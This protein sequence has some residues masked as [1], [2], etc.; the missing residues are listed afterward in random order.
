MEEWIKCYSKSRKR[1][2]YF[3]QTTGRSV[4]SV[5]ELT[6][7]NKAASAKTTESP[8]GLNKKTSKVKFKA[9]D[10]LNSKNIIKSSSCSSS[11]ATSSKL[12]S[13]AII[14]SNKSIIIEKTKNK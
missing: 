9:K 10:K 1:D 6:I 11:P 5:E 13:K 2:Y 7:I 14:S 4:W 12:L 3:N 8:L